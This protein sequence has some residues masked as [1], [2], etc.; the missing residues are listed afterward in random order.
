[1]FL[2]RAARAGWVLAA[3]MIGCSP[4][5]IRQDG[6]TEP[7]R[8]AWWRPGAPDRLVL[9][10]GEIPCRLDDGTDGSDEVAADPWRVEEARLQLRTALCR[11][12]AAHLVIALRRDV[13]ERVGGYPGVVGD[14]APLPRE[15]TAIA[16][17]VEET[18]LTSID[19]WVRGTGV[20][21]VEAR[22]D[23]AD[24]GRVWIDAAADG[25]LSGS[26][27]LPIAGM[28]GRF[29]AEAC[30]VGDALDLVLGGAFACP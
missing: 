11:E 1:M 17:R 30:P 10:N 24:G 6:A 26:F 25:R 3:A 12:G 4:G 18:V 21:E 13:G 5:W 14:E 20:V 16:L 7:L 15:A 27:D 29:D 23:A 9:S 19:G 2:R 28:E 22:V 8:S